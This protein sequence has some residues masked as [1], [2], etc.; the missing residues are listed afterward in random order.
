[1]QISPA[2]PGATGAPLVVEQMDLGA[3]DRPPDRRQ[4]LAIGRDHAGRRD[5]GALGR[6]VIVDEREGQVAPPGARSACR[7]R[8][9]GRA[10]RASA[11]QS[12]ATIGSASGVGAKATLDPLRHQPVAQPRRI[13]PGRV[14]DQHQRAAGGE[15][16][17]D[18]PGSRIEAEPG[19][20]AGPRADTDF[21]G[22]LVPVDQRGEIGMRHLDCLGRAGRAR[23][24]DHIGKRVGVDRF[25]S[26]R[27]AAS[28][29]SGLTSAT[30]PPIHAPAP[31]LGD[32]GS[33]ASIRHQRRK[34]LLGPGRIERQIGSARAPR[35]EHRHDLVDRAR[36]ADSDKIAGT[37]ALLAQ[38]G[39][40]RANSRFEITITKRGVAH[41]RGRIRRV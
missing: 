11:G 22:V 3:G 23:G 20:M 5:H 21:E 37:H 1:M 38:A 16:R 18:F 7:H 12:I 10:A 9:A 28:P 34:P 41:N 8:S 39:G 33:A 19:E 27:R 40:K 32:Q 31:G 2:S 30:S 26:E 4:A 15:R 24:V 36:Q 25:G 29:A 6:P 14:I 13:E 17:P 35:G